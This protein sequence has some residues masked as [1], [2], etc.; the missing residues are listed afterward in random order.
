MFERN[1]E[2][3]YQFGWYLTNRLI[4]S[5]LN[6]TIVAPKTYWSLLKS[7]V[8]GK[9]IP[10]MPPILVNDQLMINFFEKVNL[11]NKFLTQQCNTIKNYNTVP[12]DLVFET[13]KF[14]YDR[15]I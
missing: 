3:L 1:L 2:N 4:A 6:D 12:N 13:T 10:V 5:K 7:F 15:K 11:F 14:S 9:K 8:N